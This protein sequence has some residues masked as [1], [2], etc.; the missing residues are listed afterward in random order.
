L[1]ENQRQPHNE[2]PC[3]SGYPMILGPPVNQP[4]GNDSIEDERSNEVNM[5]S[6]H[7]IEHPDNRRHGG[8]QRLGF[9]K[10]E[11]ALLGPEYRSVPIIL[12]TTGDTIRIPPDRPDIEKCHHAVGGATSWKRT[13]E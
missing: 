1:L 3:V 6:G 8:R 7:R 11:G 2:S 4:P 12:K 10:G 9:R 5:V 13:R